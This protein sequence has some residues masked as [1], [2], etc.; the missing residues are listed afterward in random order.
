MLWNWLRPNQTVKTNGFVQRVGADSYWV[1]LPYLKKVIL[2]QGD[3]YANH[4]GGKGGISLKVAE[5]NGAHNEDST[6]LA[7]WI[8]WIDT[9]DFDSLWNEPLK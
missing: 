9:V 3:A 8:E 6:R 5:V 1:G 4:T 7:P 2:N